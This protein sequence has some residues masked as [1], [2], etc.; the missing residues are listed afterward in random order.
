M[1]EWA[2]RFQ[3]LV[4]GDFNRGSAEIQALRQFGAR[5]L[6][7]GLGSAATKRRL[8]QDGLDISAVGQSRKAIAEAAADRV[9]GCH[10]ALFTAGDWDDAFEAVTDVE[11]QS[12]IADG[13]RMMPLLD[14]RNE[15][16]PFLK[17]PRAWAAYTLARSAGADT[18]SAKEFAKQQSGHKEKD[19][20]S[21]RGRV[22][23]T[24][25][26]RKRRKG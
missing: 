18:E 25:T 24:A 14:Q 7:V 6:P 26:A 9:G 2:S 16:Y 20:H 19:P 12:A 1:F 21:G 3:I 23:R 17:T 11:Q 8:E 13:R 4:V 22:N 15:R 10:A 5:V